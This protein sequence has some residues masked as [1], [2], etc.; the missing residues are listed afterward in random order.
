MRDALALRQEMQRRADAMK[1]PL[2][3]IM[4][5]P[6]GMGIPS[7]EVREAL[8]EHGTVALQLC[9][10]MLSVIEGTGVMASMFRTVNRALLT[11]M[12]RANRGHTVSTLDEALRMLP[13]EVAHLRGEIESA[14]QRKAPSPALAP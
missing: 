8:R 14:M 1:T 10:H 5:F 4:V 3:M 6:E 2:V 12:G 13:P 11:M 7:A 9:S